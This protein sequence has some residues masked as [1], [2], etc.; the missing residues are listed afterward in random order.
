LTDLTKTASEAIRFLASGAKAP[1]GWKQGKLDEIATA[2]K[3]SA[4]VRF[5]FI[6]SLAMLVNAVQE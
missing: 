5:T 3:I 4:L 2:K 1:A 6:D